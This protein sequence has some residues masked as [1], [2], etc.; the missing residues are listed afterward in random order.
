[1]NVIVASTDVVAADATACRIMGIDPYTIFHIKNAEERGLGCIKNIEII[2]EDIN[3]IKR[4]F[5]YPHSIS[6]KLKFK[7]FDF[8]MDFT[9]R[10]KGTTEEERAYR[11]IMNLMNTMPVIDKNECQ[12]CKR[13]IVICPHDAITNNIEIRY[14][15]CKKCMVCMEACPYHAIKSSGIP[16]LDATKDICICVLRVITKAFTGRLYK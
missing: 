8:A 4:K 14:E 16:I 12:S 2:G 5:K 9:A 1:M 15:K 11:V 13:C 10:L 6:K 3:T 7:L